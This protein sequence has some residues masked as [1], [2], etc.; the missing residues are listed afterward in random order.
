MD[1]DDRNASAGGRRVAAGKGGKVALIVAAAVAAVVLCAYFALCAMAGGNKFWP[2][3]SVMGIDLSGLT[4]AEAATKLAEEV[5]VK[6]AEKDLE[7]YE[8]TSGAQVSLSAEGLVKTDELA[9][10]MWTARDTGSFFGR[11]GRYLARVLSKQGGAVTP[12]ALTMT[13]E[14]EERLEQALAQVAQAAGVTGNDTTW[15][16]RGDELILTKGITGK[17]IDAEKA[18]ADVKAALVGDSGRVEVAITEA[19]PA[20]PDLDAIHDQVFAEPVNASLDVK[21]MDVI[22][23]AQGRDFDV[24]AAKAALAAAAEGEPCSVP[25]TITEP[26]VT[27]EGLK[28]LLFRDTLGVAATKATGTA[29]R[30]RSIRN[31]AGFINGKILLPGEEFSYNGTCEPYTESNGYG[32]ATAYVGG[33]SVD[34]V[35]GGICQ[36]SSTLYWATLKANLKV[37]ERHCHMYFPSYIAGGLDATVYGGG[38]DYKFVNDTEYPIKL[39]TYVDKSNYVHVAIYGT[40]LTGIHGEP[41]STNKIITKYAVTVYEPNA[42]IPVGTTQRDSTRTAYNA[43]SI[44]AYQKLVDANG[45]VISTTFLHKDNYRGRN[46]V[47]WYNPADAGRWGIDTSTGL[48]TLTPVVPPSELPAESADPNLTDPTATTSPAPTDP[49]VTPPPAVVTDPPAV[50]TPPPVEPT[51]AVTDP[52]PVVTPPPV[53]TAEPVLTPPPAVDPVPSTGSDPLPP[54]Q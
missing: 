20:E 15:E 27:T 49:V 37:T 53:Q 41:Y 5:P 51:P 29:D 3:T 4:Y 11:G 31:A 35:A 36:L 46:A 9:D 43:A 54:P 26:S 52:G 30:I 24:A 44:E 42:S 23:S 47:I 18:R 10:Q 1:R 21:T 12:T 14:G 38:A 17:A 13:P 7:L 40:N 48:Q 19:P 22:A 6:L 34:T 50:V 33:K 25:L 16:V 8:P 28:A 39:E 45:N 32:R 2:H